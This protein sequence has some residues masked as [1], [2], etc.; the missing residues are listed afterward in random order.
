MK[1]YFQYYPKV[2]VSAYGDLEEQVLTNI[3]H[4]VALRK[5]VLNNVSVYTPWVLRDGD[6][7]EIVADAY[8]GSPQYHW[9]VLMSNGI[10]D[11]YYEWVMSYEVFNRFLLDQYGSVESTM[12]TVHHYED[13]YGNHIDATT[14][15]ATP[16]EERKSV[17]IYDYWDGVNESRRHIRLLDRRFLPEVEKEMSE[18]Y[19][20][21]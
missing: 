1:Q 21:Q 9:V 3:V 18:I 16:E 8:Y 6:T 5:D 17:S 15:A 2:L 12:I 19:R 14:Y 7:P 4:K 10:N 13:A 20:N 11:G